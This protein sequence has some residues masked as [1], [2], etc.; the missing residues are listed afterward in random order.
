MGKRKVFYKTDISIPQIEHTNDAMG[1]TVIKPELIPPLQTSVVFE[2]NAT[3]YRN[4]DFAQ[5]YGAGIDYI[6]YSCQRQI[7]R[8]LARQDGEI[9]ASS[10]TS[11]CRAGLNIFLDF[12]VIT[13]AA[14]NRSLTLADI[15]RSLIDSYLGFLRLRGFN[16]NY[17]KNS[18][19]H[20]KSVLHALGRRGLFPLITFGDNATFPRNPFPNSN[21]KYAGETALPKLQRQA[22]TSALKQAVM[23]IWRD[24]VSITSMLLG[25]VVLII[26]LHTGRNTTSLLEME[27]DCLKNHPKKNTV[28][29]WLP[30]RRGRNTSKVALRTDS[31]A[32]RLQVSSPTVRTNLKR[33]IERVIALTEPLVANAPSELKKR[34]WLHHTQTGPSAGQIV[35]MSNGTLDRAIKLLVSEY[36]LTDTEGQPLHLNVSRL[37]KTFANRIFELLEGD[38]ITT[39]IALGNTPKVADRNYLAPGKNARHNWRFM[40]E[41]LVKE[42][43]NYTIGATYKPIPTGHCGDTETG[44]S[45]TKLEGVVCFDFLSCLRCKHYAVTEE[46]LYKLFSFYFRIYEERT[47]MDKRRWTRDYA[48][49]PRLIDDYIIAEGIRRGIFKPANVEAARQRA[50]EEPHPFWS[51]DV[52]P[53]LDIFS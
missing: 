18:Y 40:G 49:I 6:T 36:K 23:P 19:S 3:S 22:F 4:F 11:Y 47:R 52:L 50:R 30:K 34:V 14:L 24:D 8:F 7:E 48:H 1:Q 26:A 42:L 53:V 39:A 45:G 28:F 27:R 31:L 43:L 12:M 41:I 25:Y 15:D 33:L 5:W 38:L 9:E 51:T 10:V 21:R 44:R 17:Q 32:E 16:S 13:A 20:T 29:L 46:D 2:R 37:R 35:S